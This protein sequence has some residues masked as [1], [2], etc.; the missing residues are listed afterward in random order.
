M[1]E[2]TASLHHSVTEHNESNQHINIATVDEGKRKFSHVSQVPFL[3]YSYTLLYFFLFVGNICSPDVD[4]N[5][6]MNEIT[7]DQPV[8]HVAAQVHE[9]SHRLTL[10]N[11]NTGKAFSYSIIVLF[12]LWLCLIILNY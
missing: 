5:I 9:R 12:I 6:D 3:Q 11:T 4:K 1:E 8:V 10:S 2:F 7:P